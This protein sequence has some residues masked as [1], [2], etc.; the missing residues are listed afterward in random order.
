MLN[1][2]IYTLFKTSIRARLKNVLIYQ[3]ETDISG[4]EL[5]KLVKVFMD[6]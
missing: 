1:K 3:G 4:Y 5:N 6:L 2:I